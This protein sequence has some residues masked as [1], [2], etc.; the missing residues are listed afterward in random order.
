MNQNTTERSF[1]LPRAGNGALIILLVLDA[2][3]VL[4]AGWIFLQAEPSAPQLWVALV[5]LL[6]LSALF[7]WL[8]IGQLRSRIVF[9]EQGLLI[10][11]PLYR[12]TE[13]WKTLK[14]E[15]AEIIQDPLPDTWKL[16]WRMN[17]IGL[18]GYMVGWFSTRT[19]ERVFAAMTKAPVVRIPTTGRHHLLLSVDDPE[20]F[21]SALKA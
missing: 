21:L 4:L 10:E 17:G 7:S 9:K 15:D 1:A 6:S 14:L 12:R 5:I 16:K 3:M 19:G 18:P 20:G 11:V 8:M 2:T 13:Q